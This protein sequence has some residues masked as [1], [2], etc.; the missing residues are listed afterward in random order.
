MIRVERLGEMVETCIFKSKIIAE[1]CRICLKTNKDG[2]VS[3]KYDS[4][5]SQLYEFCVGISVHE[6][7]TPQVLCG[8]C[9]GNIRECANF[10]KQCQ[11]ADE[12]WRS[13]LDEQRRNE[14]FSVTKETQTDDID[15]DVDLIDD[16][17]VDLNDNAQDELGEAEGVINKPEQNSIKR[18]KKKKA[19]RKRFVKYKNL[20]ITYRE[21][22]Y[23][24]K[25]DNKRYCQKGLVKVFECSK[26]K[27][28]YQKIK[29][30]IKHVVHT[31]YKNVDMNKI[32]VIKK[33][34]KPIPKP[35]D[36]DEL[37]CGIC[38]FSSSCA[39]DIK[40]HLQVHWNENDLKCKQCDYTGTDLAELFGHRSA[41]QPY[42]FYSKPPNRAC[43]I[44]NKRTVTFMKLQFHYRSVH[45]KKIGG[46]C[47]V[48]RKTYKSYK[49]WRNHE[50]LHRDSRYICDL[51][52]NRFLFR[53]QIKSHLAEHADVRQ[54]I[55]DICGKGFKRRSYLKKHCNTVHNSEPVTCPHCDRI[56][57]CPI[58][59]KEHLKHVNK[60]KNFQCEVCSSKFA[61]A[62]ALKKHMFW[63]TDERP[64]GCD[65]CGAKYK[66]KS[67]LKVHML[68]HTGQRPH[69]CDRCDQCFPTPMQLRRHTSIHTGERPHKCNVCFRTFYYKKMLLKHVSSKHNHSDT[70]I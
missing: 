37:F 15:S 33:Y 52:G 20:I 36:T 16:N 40:Q 22:G 13:V 25:S 49:T 59:L 38:N 63:H 65:K 67:Y 39:N 55:C 45:L 42:E 58:H 46:L 57:R 56:Y 48:C 7:D 53:N 11:A 64:Y 35:E 43:H 2:S 29:C 68:K 19:I 34:R 8:T 51:C 47:S 24:K 21:E 54:N 10:I 27:K 4:E 31:C 23:L 70:K 62:P 44:C 32:V 30:L 50:R 17:D 14:K 28:Q 66:A 41:H 1:T 6:D 69:T 61:T 18:K 60:A 26:C 9:N 5:L 12:H 3:L